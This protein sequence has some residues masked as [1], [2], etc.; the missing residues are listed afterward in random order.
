MAE[1]LLNISGRWLCGEKQHHEYRVQTTRYV[2]K[3][4]RWVFLVHPPKKTH[5]KKST[6]LL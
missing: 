1:K 6:L 2:P 3:K 4:T 5:P